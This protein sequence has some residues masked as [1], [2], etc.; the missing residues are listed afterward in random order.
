MTASR[1]L[2]P[3]PAPQEHAKPSWKKNFTALWRV[4]ARLFALFLSILGWDEV[5]VFRKIPLARPRRPSVFPAIIR[6]RPPSC[7]CP[8]QTAQ[9]PLHPSRL[10]CPETP[11][12]S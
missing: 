4:L 10:A 5:Y 9:L 12:S 11:R 8:M 3:M 2:T 6:S 7:V 1:Q